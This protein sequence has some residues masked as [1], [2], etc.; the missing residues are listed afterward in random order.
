MNRLETNT[1]RALSVSDSSLARFTEF[2]TLS[3][4]FEGVEDD[5]KTTLTSVQ[6][7]IE[8]LVKS[9]QTEQVKQ[10]LD[11]SVLACIDIFLSVVTVCCS[12]RL[13]RYY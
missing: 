5:L 12:H 3:D 7:D 1:D 8:V 11:V 10:Q 9:Q 2:Y 13:N 4:E 6:K